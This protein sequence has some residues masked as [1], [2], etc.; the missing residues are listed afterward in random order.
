VKIKKKS[1]AKTIL[2]EVLFVFEQPPKRPNGPLVSRVP[3]NGHA[4][5]CGELISHLLKQRLFARKPTR[6]FSL[7]EKTITF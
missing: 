7:S 1:F 3:F 2:I 5:R 4:F 6:G